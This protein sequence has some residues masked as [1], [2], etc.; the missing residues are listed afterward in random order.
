MADRSERDALRARRKW[1]S[2]KYQ[3]RM[4]ARVLEIIEEMGVDAA[5]V[6]SSDLIAAIEL[7][8]E[9]RRG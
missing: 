7:A 9:E 4:R 6:R 8:E 2:I 1:H 5:T 3:P